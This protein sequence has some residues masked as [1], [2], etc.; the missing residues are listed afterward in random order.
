MGPTNVALLQLFR[1]DQDLRAAQ[2]SLESASKSVRIQERRIADLSEKLKLAQSQL[3][4]HQGKAAQL[5][6][7][8]KARE[9]RIE[10]LRQQ[11]QTAQ[12]H[13]QYQTFLTEINTE[14]IDRAKVE[15]ELLK[16]MEVVEKIQP[17]VNDL[18][19]QMD[20]EQKKCEQIKHELADKL[21]E[22]KAEVDRKQAVRDE[23]A[24]SVPAKALDT[25][26]RI[27]E[28]WDGEAMAAI[29][30]PDRRR[31]EYVCMACNMALV[32]DMYNRLHS[33]D[34]M[35]FCPNCQRLMYIPDS[36]PPE[37]AINKHKERRETRGKAESA[38]AGRQVSAIDVAR[39]ITPEP[40]EDEAPATAGKEPRN[41]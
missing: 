40:D 5:E 35:V 29:G 1:A 4:E 6:L 38:V 12:S 32:P 34:E 15:E 31:E 7:D 33:R 24:K 13:K 19:S 3:Q 20:A 8:V 26:D 28:R 2:G 36:L 30:K 25:F 22:L 14:K 37:M 9:T 17:E 16:V 23:A 11:Q 39:S 27:A 10:R 21:A 18:T 41:S